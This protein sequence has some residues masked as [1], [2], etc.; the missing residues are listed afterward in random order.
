[1]YEESCAVVVHFVLCRGLRGGGGGGE[2]V[3]GKMSAEFRDFRSSYFSAGFGEAQVLVHLVK[4]AKALQ[5]GVMEGNDRIV[6]IFDK[7]RTEVRGRIAFMA[8][9][10]GSLTT[11]TTEGN[12][13]TP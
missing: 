3:S 12:K 9:K 6:L 11:P 2:S 7:Q 4:R 8:P 10:I 13:T 1:M 5:P